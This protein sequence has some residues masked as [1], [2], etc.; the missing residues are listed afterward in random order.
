MNISAPFVRIDRARSALILSRGKWAA[1]VH[2]SA[3]PGQITLYRYLA[4][5]EGGKYADIYMPMVAELERVQKAIEA[6]PI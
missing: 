2:I 5:R 3:L 6:R 4:D 1:E